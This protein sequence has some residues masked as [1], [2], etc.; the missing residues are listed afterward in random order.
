MAKTNYLQEV[1]YVLET[2]FEKLTLEMNHLRREMEKE[3]EL[4]SKT[5]ER[6]NSNSS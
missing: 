2:Y 6:K 1:L 4:E 3:Y 5:P